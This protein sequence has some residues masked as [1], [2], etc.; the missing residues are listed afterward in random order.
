M[1]RRLLPGGESGKECET[2]LERNDAIRAIFVAGRSFGYEEFIHSVLRGRPFSPGILDAVD[3]FQLFRR[4]RLFSAWRE[5]PRS[6]AA[7]P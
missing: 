2:R 7:T 3:G 5:M 1:Y 6:D 4:R